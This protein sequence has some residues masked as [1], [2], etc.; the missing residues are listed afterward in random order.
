MLTDGM[1][2][3]DAKRRAAARAAWENLMSPGPTLSRSERVSV[4]ESARMAWAGTSSEGGRSLIEEVGHWI[5]L[6]AGGITAEAVTT[7]ELAGLGR[8]QYLE[9]VGVASRLANIDF[10]ARGLGA[11]LPSIP[12]R[13]DEPATGA[14]HD[15]A[16]MHDGWVPS[17]G[18]LHAITV[19]EALPSDAESF[20]ALHE[21]FYVPFIHFMDGDYCDALH[22][23]QIE[24]V[25]AR[26]SYLNECFY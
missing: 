13:P 16:A 15:A 3:P 23:T 19:L 10:Y 4:I 17:T 6:D 22:R 14:V 24:W 7:I 5:A 1:I 26:S 12:A 11:S 20:K 2:A 8:F 25:A 9:A 21:P 18:P